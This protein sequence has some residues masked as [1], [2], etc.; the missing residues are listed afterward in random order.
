MELTPEKLSHMVNELPRRL[1]I[2]ALGL[3]VKRQ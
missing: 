1:A 3:A 2:L